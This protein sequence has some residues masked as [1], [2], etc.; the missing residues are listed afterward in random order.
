[1]G[2]AS[3]RNQGEIEGDFNGIRFSGE[4]SSGRLDNLRQGTVSSD[5]R[6]IDIQGEDVTI[7][8]SGTIVGTG[9]QRNG[10]VYADDG[11]Q[12]YEI[13]NFR[14][15]VID[16]GEGNQGAGISLSLAE[17]GNGDV[18]I[19]NNGTITGRGQAGAGAGTAGDGIRLEGV[20]GEGFEPA[21][22]E[23]TITNAGTVTSESTQ[24]TTGAFRAVNSVDFQGELV[25]EKGGLF[26]GAQNGVYFG[27]GD[28]D[29]GSFENRGTVTSDSRALNIDGE[30][31]EV[32]NA[33]EIVGTGDQRNGTVYADGTADDFSFV[34]TETGLVDAG[35][36]NQG[37]GFGAEIGGAADGA[38][39]FTLENDGTIQGRGQAG[40]ASN[41]AGDGVRIGNVGNTGTAEVELDNSGTIASESAQGTTAGIRFVNG[42]SFSGELNNS[43]TISGVQNGLYFGNPVNGVGADHSN[44]VVNNLEGGVISSDSRALN[45]DGFGLTV[46]NEGEIVGTGDQRNGTVYSD[47]TADGY[48]FTNAE[49]GVVDAGI[50][51]NGSAVSLQTGDVDGDVVSASLLNEGLFQGR[52]D[53]AEGNTVGDGLRVFSSV[54]DVSFDGEI[55]NEGL[56]AGSTDSDVAAGLRVDGGVTVLGT[57]TNEGEIR[58]T[59]TAIDATDGGSITFVNESGGVVNGNVL[60]G[61][62]ADSLTNLGTINGD[63]D[64]G[65]GDDEI[66]AGDG[67]NTLVGGL[68]DD[69][70]DGGEG[71]DTADFSDIDV[72]VTVDLGPDGDGT[73]TRDTG[74]SVSVV[75]QVVSAP[76]QFGSAIADGAGF[77]EEAV[78]GNLYYNIHT[79]D[80]PGGEIR[81]QLLVESD[82]TEGDIRTIELAGGLDAAQ[83]P[84]PTSD[85]LAT[86]EATVTIT[87]NLVTGEVS[88]SSELSVTGLNEADL[89]TPIPGTVSAIHLHNAPTGQNGPVVQDTLVDA[90]ATLDASPNATGTGVLGLDVIDN[91]LETDTLVSIENVIGSDDNDI[92]TGSDDGNVLSGGDGD[93][94][95]RG[96]GGNDVLIGGAGADVFQFAPGDGTDLVLDFE[97][98]VDL[99]EFEGLAPGFD[100][101]ANTTQDGDDALISLGDGAVRLENV[102]AS[103]LDANDFIV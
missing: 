7:R 82:V 103:L 21:L 66:L 9:D 88:Y 83:E 63:I 89:L 3:I 34:N 81:G 78:A 53:A 48:S 68:G 27:F 35:A 24:G 67:S 69:T 47:G 99:L 33:G 72:G 14:S 51:N 80:F 56:I 57:I 36:G 39:T 75:D 74:F 49:T 94:V 45:I 96:E 87:Q 55:F 76:N 41:L 26:A 20:R 5:S 50:G 43:G 91:V 2:S 73:A 10:T 77:V 61:D 23:G 70:L 95:L 52:G 59:V 62:S 38:N 71:S 92:I 42:I 102:D 64:G 60:L 15:G 100:L 85:S 101:A 22:F 29:G 18:S 13:N 19:D 17:D 12:D 30:G 8:N 16:A 65:G 28:H 1:T 93:D 25:N 54:D 6:A 98:G 44:G 86:G 37:S 90:G 40:A 97:I 58:G 31:L 84:G 11:A 46:N 79:A 4:E 32:L